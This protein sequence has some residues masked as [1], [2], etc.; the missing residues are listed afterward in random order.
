MACDSFFLLLYTNLGWNSPLF[1]FP[2]DHLKH[3]YAAD[4]TEILNNGRGWSWNGVNCRNTSRLEL[5]IRHSNSNKLLDL[6]IPGDFSLATFLCGFQSPTMLLVIRLFSYLFDPC[7]PASLLWYKK[8]LMVSD[9]LRFTYSGTF[10]WCPTEELAGV[11]NF[12]L[13]LSSSLASA[14]GSKQYK[15]ILTHRNH[16]LRR[17]KKTSKSVWSI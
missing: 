16:P 10:S 5:K 13:S 3:L 17:Q 7:F 6:C 12:S 4:L 1:W 15:Y 11:L 9:K 8:S 14:G 2:S